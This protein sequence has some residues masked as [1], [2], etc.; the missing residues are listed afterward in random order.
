MAKYS[1]YGKPWA[2]RTGAKDVSSCSTAEEVM[3]QAGLDFKVDK[4]PLVAKMPFNFNKQDVLLDQLNNGE[5]FTHDGNVYRDCDSMFATYR[6][7]IDYPLGVVKSK[8][9]VVQNTDAFKF[10]NDAIG[11]DRA[12]WQTAGCFGAGER[13]FVSAKL[14]DDIR[15]NG[16]VVENYL[17]FTSTH[18]G[19][20]GVTILFTPIRV[21]C[22]NTLNA[23]IK[24]TDCYITFRHTKSVHSNIDRAKEILG[25]ARQQTEDTS[26]LLN[27]LSNIQMTDLQVAEY[28]SRVHLTEA[29]YLSVVDYDKVNGFKRLAA[30]DYRTLEVT[31]IS[32]RKANIIGSTYNYYFEG[33]GQNE[34]LGNA[35]GAYNAVTG[36]YSNVANMEGLR[37]MDSL[38]YGNANKVMSKALSTAL[39][40]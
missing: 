34:I 33:I 16:D 29:E 22:Q 20:G 6:T 7:D 36:Y 30:R 10:F 21:V 39:T 19:S 38:L 11:Q 5:I 12:I 27:Q 40:Y 18:D 1:I 3:V 31:G 14:P 32:T 9:E 23:A 13:I 35:Y 2:P 25:I 26:L 4:C 15:V 24:T 28:I 37:R 17:V 8:Y